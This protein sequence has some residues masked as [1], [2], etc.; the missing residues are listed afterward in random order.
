MADT[1]TANDPIRSAI[2]SAATPAIALSHLD[3]PDAKDREFLYAIATDAPAVFIDPAKATAIAAHETAL[4]TS[5]RWNRD[6]NPGGI[7]IVADGTPQPFKI[8]SATEAAHAFLSALNRLVTDRRPEPWKLSAPVAEWLDT[9]WARHCD[10]AGAVVALGD[11]HRKFTYPDGDTGFTWAEDQQWTAGVLARAG[12]L[13]PN[14]GPLNAATE[15]DV[16]F[17]KVPRPDV[18]ELLVKKVGPG[19]GYYQLP[20]P[21]RILGGCQHI[22]AGSG[23][24]QFYADFFGIGGERESDALVDFMIDASGRIAMLNDPWGYRSPWANGGTDGLE[25]DGP[26]FVAKLGAE[27]VNDCLYATEHIRAGSEP[28]PDAMVSATIDLDA[29]MFDSAGVRW[30]SFPVNQL[31]DLVTWMLHREFTGKG[32]NAPDE[33]PGAWESAP[34]HINAQ[35][36]AIRGRIKQYQAGGTGK[37]EPGDPTPRPSK[38]AYPKGWNA[39]TAKREFGF[40]LMTREDGTTVRRGFNPD[41]PLS[42]AWLHRV[43]TD[44]PNGSAAALRGF[45]YRTPAG[46]LGSAV[47]FRN[48]WLAIKPGHRAGWRWGDRLA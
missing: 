7:G 38:V 30:D 24:L 33:C 8:A 19:H 36:A 39:G 28:W 5:P 13:Y 43:R 45:E 22:T 21:R 46:E 29:Y 34:A 27:A 44:K 48:G 20:A 35:Q 16:V 6:L 31:V 9:V 11:M 1:L 2:S 47:A 40:V 23:T 3:G 41:G 18:L 25:G 17:G 14:L 12:Q 37:D 42:L 26:A 10:A 4:F 15:N 32:G